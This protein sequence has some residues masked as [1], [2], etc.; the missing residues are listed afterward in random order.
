[1]NCKSAQRMVYE[2]V[3]RALS[4]DERRL[5][6]AHLA[7]CER[8]RAEAAVLDA[9]IETV[10]TA[11]AAKPTEAFLANVMAQLPAPLRSSWFAPALVFPRLVFAFTLAAAALVWLYRASLSEIVGNFPPVQTVSGPVTTAIRDIQAYLQAQAGAV[12]NH[13]PI[14]ASTSVEW[15]SMLLVATTLAVGYLLIR[16]AENPDVGRSSF[17]IGRRY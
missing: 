6:D 8:C 9:L 17:R 11:P 5:L 12:L 4:P 7:G 14:P 1:M 10:E 13:L 2:A 16:A 15:G 3:D